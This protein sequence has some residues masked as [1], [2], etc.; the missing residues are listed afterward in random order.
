MAPMSMIWGVVSGSWVVTGLG[1][2]V[3]AHG[4]GARAR[5]VRERARGVRELARGVRELADVCAACAGRRERA[6]AE[7]Q[8][9]RAERQWVRAERQWVRA[10]T[11]ECGAGG[12]SQCRRDFL[13][14]AGIFLDSAKLSLYD[15]SHLTAAAPAGKLEPELLNFIHTQLHTHKDCSWHVR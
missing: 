11:S 13:A 9:V 7:R 4:D 2:E 10:D 12:F 3:S 6:R 8:W 15:S 5:G 1:G 14:R